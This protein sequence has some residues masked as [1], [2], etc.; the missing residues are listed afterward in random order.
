MRKYLEQIVKQPN[1]PGHQKHAVRQLQANHLGSA[2]REGTLFG[3]QVP[4]NQAASLGNFGEST[5]VKFHGLLLS[6]R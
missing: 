1:V 3:L 6:E 5:R 4:S 2:G